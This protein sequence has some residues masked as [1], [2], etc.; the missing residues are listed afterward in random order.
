MFT[1]TFC[2]RPSA[3]VKE[4]TVAQLQ[5]LDLLIRKER[6]AVSLDAA[7]PAGLIDLMARVVVAVFHEEEGASNDRNRLQSKDQTGA[8]GS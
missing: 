5:L 8:P 3:D 6:N 7:T 1:M 2:N 4:V